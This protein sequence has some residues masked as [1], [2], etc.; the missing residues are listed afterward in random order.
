[1][2]EQTSTRTALVTGGNRGIGL[3]TA[4]ALAADGVRVVVGS[5]SGKAP[6][7]LPAVTV[8]VSDTAS[9]DAGFAAA[10]EILGGPVEILVANA[11]IT[12]D[13]LLLR[14]SDEDIESVLQT[15]L[16]GAIR[17]AR[18]ASRGMIRLKRGRMIFISSVVGAMGSPGQVTYAASKAGLVGVA[19]SISRELAGRGITANVIAPGFVTTDM[20]AVLPEQVSES[21]R[22]Q[23]PMGRFGRPEEVAAAAVFLASSAASYVTG[24]VLP[25]DGGI[26]MGQ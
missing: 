3:A 19:R 21:Y 1:M 6:D 17:C 9:V 22:G 18:R 5:R 13:Q 26:G 12:R 8:D 7:G 10:E 20:T 24:A 4:R 25:V 23:I 11:G 14:L 15:N 16:T 2:S